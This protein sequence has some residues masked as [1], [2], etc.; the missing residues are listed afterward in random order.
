MAD[1]QPVNLANLEQG[2]QALLRILGQM[3]S[4][5]QQGVSQFG[6]VTSDAF[7]AFQKSV[8]ATAGGTEIIAA[9]SDRRY[10]RI[11][12]IGANPVFLGAAGVTTATGYRLAVNAELLMQN[13]VSLAA[14]Y[15]IVAA[16]TET[17]AVLEW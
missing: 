13:S 8:A 9:N 1:I 10:L 5:F 15:G 11:V 3:V 14:I 7:N 12:N 6:P 4:D 17:V 2:Q 16:A